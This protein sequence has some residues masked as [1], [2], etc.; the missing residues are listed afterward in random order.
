[1]ALPLSSARVSMDPGK[2]LRIMGPASV[3]VDS[4]RVRVLGAEYGP[5]SRIVIHRLRSYV[6]KAVERS[7]LS[8]TMGSGASIEE[9]APGEEVVDE[10]ERVAN[11]IVSS[12]RFVAM[13]TGPVDSGKT[14]LSTMIANLALSRGLRTAVV[15]LDVGQGDLAPPTFI[16]M[17][18]LDQPVTWLRLL[19]GDSYRFVGH[20]T[21]VHNPYYTRFILGARELVEE[22]RSRG[23]Q[24]IVVN[25]CGWVTGLS[26]VEMLIEIAY[27][28]GAT[29]VVALDDALY[30]RLAT[31]LGR[32]MHVVR[33]P[34]P[35]IV[36]ERNRVDR[37]MLRRH[38]YMRFFQDAK[39]V[40]LELRKLMVVGSCC[41]SGR[42][43][44]LEALPEDLR[45]A[46]SRYAASVYEHDD[47]VIL[48]SRR[49]VPHDVAS[50]VRNAM[51][52]ELYVANPSTA[53]GL[54]CAVL[55]PSLRIAAPALIDSVDLEKGEICLV[56]EY[57]G[58]I[59]GLIIGRVRISEEW[60]EIS[61]VPRCPI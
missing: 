41:L 3:V 25:T 59:A 60:D 13:V 61:R 31:A 26:A 50:R 46:L 42:R 49:E 4:G 40:C 54:L 19:K 23:C 38:Q 15:D 48:W 11:E 58:E 36:R 45:L 14:S 12:G 21:P 2:L 18:V 6:I 35:R 32:R 5:G 30:E 51:G 39:R 53:K 20:I 10:W 24:A 8:I 27:V 55:D 1:M 37:R 43:V 57:G 56:T 22:A 44:P 47:V 7:V 9:P 52:R 34:R 28:V 16:A 29:H 17:K 33:A